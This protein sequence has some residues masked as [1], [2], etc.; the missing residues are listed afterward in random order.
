[1]L[2][3]VLYNRSDRR[4]EVIH[5]DTGEIVEFP[6]G[7]DGRQAAFQMAVALENGTLYELAAS[8]IADAP[9]LATRV[10]RACELVIMEQVTLLEP[11]E[12]P[13]AVAT[14]ESS[15]EYGEYIVS[16]MH[17]QWV[18]ECDDWRGGM[19]PADESGPRCKHSLA[20]ELAQVLQLLQ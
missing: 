10:W 6:A 11:G 12:M 19:C 20:A 7:R 1:M 2:P 9:M 8:K 5:P 3:T 13:P 18:C 4:Y 14:V 16:R 15:N 17:D